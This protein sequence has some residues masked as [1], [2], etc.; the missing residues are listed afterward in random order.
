M[1]FQKRGEPPVRSFDE[2]LD[3][4]AKVAVEVGLGLRQGQ[5]VVMTAPLEALPLVRH[6]TH[7]AYRAGASLVTTLFSDEESTLLRFRE[8]PD[9]SF[10]KATGWLFDGMANAFRAGAARLAIVGEDPALLARRTREGGARQPGAL[11]RLPAGAGADRRLRHQ[12]DHRL[13]RHAGLGEGRVP[14]RPGGAGASPSSGT[15]SS[16]PRGSTRPTRSPP[17]RRTIATSEARAPTT[18]TRTALPPCVSAGRA[19][20]S[21]SASP[22]TTNGRAAPRRAKNGIVCNPNIPSEEVFTTPHKDRVEGHVTSTKPLSYQG[23]LIEEIAVRFEAGAIVE[24]ARQDRR[25]GA[26]Q[27]ARHRRGRPP[28]RRGRAGAVLLADRGERAAVLQH[29]LRRERREPHRARPSLLP[30]AFVN[31]GTLSEA[32]LAARGANRSLIH[33]DWMIG[34]GEIDVDGVRPDGGEEPVMRKGEWAY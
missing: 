33:I 7:H 16:P 26:R 5:E 12:L 34:S 25:G 28:P 11:A 22:T 10:D 15:P 21:S 29:A 9:A 3:L 30:N 13:L 17:G 14:R 18:S 31:G 27:G 19:P 6:I 32:E 8:A 2:R 4:L 24:A 20:T 23:T 1:N